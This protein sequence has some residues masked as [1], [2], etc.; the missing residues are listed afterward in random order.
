MLVKITRLVI[1]IWQI[2]TGRRIGQML[3]VENL[4]LAVALALPNVNIQVGPNL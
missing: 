1:T 4:R 2:Q 3:N